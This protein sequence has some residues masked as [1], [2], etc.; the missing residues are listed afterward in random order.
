MLVS[1][2]KEEVM[3]AL[4]NKPK[5]WRDGQF[6]FNY[7]DK[8]YGVARTVQFKDNIDCFYDDKYIDSFIEHC[9]NYIV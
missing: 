2:L 7:I 4:K 5:G 3:G 1:K 6:V 9:A 8:Y